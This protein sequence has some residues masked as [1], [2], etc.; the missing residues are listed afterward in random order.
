M[1]NGIEFT[2]ASIGKHSKNYTTTHDLNYCDS[3]AC[4]CIFMLSYIE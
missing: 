3:Y 2:A 1:F 4:T